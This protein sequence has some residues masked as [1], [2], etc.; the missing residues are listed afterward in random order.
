MIKNEFKF[1]RSS[2]LMMISLFAIVFIPF[3]YSI[4]FLKS[5]WDPYGNTGH[6]P[7]AVVNQDQPVT[8][9][10]VKMH[11][12]DDMVKELKKNDQLGWKFVSAKE[13]KQG[14]KDKKYYTTITLPKDFSA[15]AATVLDKNPKKMQIEYKTNDSLNYIGQVISEVG[16]KELNTQIREAVTKAYSKVMFKQVETA[17]DGFNQ[18]ADGAK[19]LSD[20]S[21]TLVNGL[22]VYTS[23][24][25]QV[26]DGVLTMQTSVVPLSNGVAQ[27]NNGAG[28]LN[29]GLQTLASK[30]G[31]LMSGASQLTSGVNQLKAGSSQIDGG[32]KQIQNQLNTNPNFSSDANYNN[33]L[34]GYQGLVTKIDTIQAA[35]GQL[36]GIVTQVQNRDFTADAEK[37][38]KL[39]KAPSPLG[40]GATFTDEN[41]AKAV[42]AAALKQS[43]VQTAQTIVDGLKAQVP[44][45][46]EFD[47]LK[48]AANGSVSMMQ[49]LRDIQNG[50]NNQLVP[51]M[52]QLDS[53]LSTL[54]D[55]SSQVSDGLTQYTNGVATAA[56]GS[57]QLASGTG[58]LNSK[59]PVLSSGVNQLAS[60][61]SQLAANSGA[62]NS[63]AGQL[64]DGNK[65][66]ATSLGDGAKKIN[67]IKLTDKTA[68]QFAAPAKLKHEN[69]SYVPNYGHA[70]APYVL[71]LALYVGA[72]VF[73]F[74]FP[75]RKV[76]MEGQS[77]T[78]WFLS[79]ITVGGLVAVTM[80]VIEP[81]LMMVAGL[82]I[83]HPGQFFAISI[84]FSL[85]SMAI[86]MF[87]SMTF[88]N[89]GRFVA[90]ILL[91]LQLGGAGGT[92]PMEVTNGFYNFIHPFL[93]MTW[94]T[95]GFREAISSGLGSGQVTQSIGVLVLFIIANLGLLWLGMD[96]LQ[97]HGNRGE[98]Q[99]DDNQKLQALEK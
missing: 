82:Q 93:P 81:A 84:A 24:V 71:S 7:V 98:S 62:L 51:G 63:G 99:L 73:N 53:G 52:D 56:N 11:A 16:A 19:Q 72:I 78:A 86:V 96:W 5:V 58:E 42:L 43:A 85:A 48:V 90:M 55:G 3:L 46:A 8:Y 69:Y 89:P 14:M 4:F 12:G 30:N 25:D 17:G 64:N 68:N 74:A 94:S 66:L 15:N 77:S 67:S 23:G 70:L 29:N 40:G 27:L 21:N 79:K 28:Q 65:T 34:A 31:E 83:D 47:Q 26:N 32:L 88:D 44:T 80:A 54:K 57:D 45:D 10:G 49:S 59:I 37:E 75:I 41:R 87:L 50:L 61:T 95:L 76:S 22:N 18:A 97:R 2:K 9:Q 60:G 91:M 38:M 20:G 36:D 6:L 13:A 92:F 33:A 39:L 35:V 1:I